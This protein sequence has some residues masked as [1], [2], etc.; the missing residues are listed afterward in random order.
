MQIGNH[1]NSCLHAKMGKVR[2]VQ[3]ARMCLIGTVNSREN[4]YIVRMCNG[5]FI[6]LFFFLSSKEFSAKAI[7][8]RIDLSSKP[9]NSL[10]RSHFNH[11]GSFFFIFCI[12]V[13]VMNG[14]NENKN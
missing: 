6:Y 11:I 8:A 14:L 12:S 10:F 4:D 5:E 7:L 1:G 3:G 2:S 13:L 9:N